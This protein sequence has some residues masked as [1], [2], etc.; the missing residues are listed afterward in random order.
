MRTPKC[1]SMLDI[2]L[3]RENPDAVRVNLEK[4][5][6]LANPQRLDDLIVIDQKWR[7]GL[8]R[9]N[10]LRHER[11]Q[12]TAGIAALKKSRE[13][14]GDEIEKG[15]VVNGRITALEKQVTE[16][17][18]KV[19]DLLMR[20]PNLLHESVPQGKDESENVEIR[21]WGKIRKLEFAPEGHIELGLALD[22]LDIERA[23]KTAEKNK[24]VWKASHNLSF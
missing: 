12:I 14:A 6:D 18:Q 21:A 11:K 13:D 8:T 17:E 16:A 22:I 15:K 23:G 20:L 3:I 1:E 5:A 2:R 24:R 9:L 10:E 7:E 19:R 4:R